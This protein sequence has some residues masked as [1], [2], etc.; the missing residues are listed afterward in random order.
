MNWSVTC[1]VRAP[2][3]CAAALSLLLTAL[4]LCL[5]IVMIYNTIDQ[6]RPEQIIPA[7]HELVGDLRRQGARALL[8]GEE[9]E[10]EGDRGDRDSSRRRSACCSRPWPCA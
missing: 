4:A 5:I 9:Q 6:M 3:P 8:H 1:A 7:R 2:A 10:R